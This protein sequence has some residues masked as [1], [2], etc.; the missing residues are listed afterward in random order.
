MDKELTENE[1]LFDREYLIGL[2]DFS[3]IYGSEF[4]FWEW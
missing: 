1:I 4:T 2:N 3:N